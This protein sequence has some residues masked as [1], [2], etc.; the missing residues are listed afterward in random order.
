MLRDAMPKAKYGHLNSLRARKTSS[1]L[2]W[3]AIMTRHC[4]VTAAPIRCLAPR[5]LGLDMLTHVDSKRTR[6]HC[7]APTAF[8]A[9][10]CHEACRTVARK[11][12]GK[13]PPIE[14]LSRVW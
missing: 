11:Q 14:C 12:R 4:R 7:P 10:V 8:C 13:K 6:E 9:R 1:G 5:L 3:R 2:S